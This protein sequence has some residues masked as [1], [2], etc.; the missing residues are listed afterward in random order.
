MYKLYWSEGTASLAPQVVLEE[1]SVEYELIEVKMMASKQCNPEFLKVSPFG[2]IP[3]IALPNGKIMTEAAAIS[4]YLI[5]QHSLDHLAPLPK[6][7]SRAEFLQWI[8]YL[9]NTIQE[10]YKRYYYNNRFLPDGRDP[11]GIREIAVKDL[12]EFW[13]PIEDA[14]K[15][16]NGSYMLGEK[17]SLLDI[18]ITMLVTWFYSMEKLFFMYPAI[19]KCY[20]ACVKHKSISKSL[21]THSS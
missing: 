16:S 13:K 7:D 11:D 21:E 3:A 19:Q 10:N 5:E 2:K 15:K 6:S 20:E 12:I 9:T 17:I 18:Y 14:L 4:L 1:A 8:T